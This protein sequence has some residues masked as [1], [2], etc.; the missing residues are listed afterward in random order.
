M[1]FSPRGRKES[2]MTNTYLLTYLDPHS[3]PSYLCTKITI[4]SPAYEPKT[5]KPKQ[6]MGSLSHKAS[7]RIGATFCLLTPSTY[8]PCLRLQLSTL[9]TAPRTRALPV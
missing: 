8:Q 1:G 7:L 9:L 2:G 3:K 4:I 6:N 5:S